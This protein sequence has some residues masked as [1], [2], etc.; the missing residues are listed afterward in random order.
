MTG[1]FEQIVE[2]IIKHDQEHPNHGIGCTCM[3]KHAVT[4]RRFLASKG[5][6]ADSFITDETAY[7][8]YRNLLVVLSYITR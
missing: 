1:I 4:L 5:L 3:D 8:S 7:R 6:T 2:E